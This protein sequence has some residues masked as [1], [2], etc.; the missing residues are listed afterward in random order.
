MKSTITNASDSD[1]ETTGTKAG[2]AIDATAVHADTRGD[3]C[4]L[5]GDTKAVD[6]CGTRATAAARLAAGRGEHAA[7]HRGGLW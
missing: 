6:A 3:S 2:H 4:R 1:A 5:L 7:C